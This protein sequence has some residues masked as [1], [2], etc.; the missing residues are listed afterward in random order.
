MHDR[1]QLTA[2]IVLILTLLFLGD[3]IACRAARGA[4][5]RYAL[6]VAIR[7]YPHT[8]QLSNLV[9]TNRDAERLA[10]SLI[11]ASFSAEDLT[12][13]YDDATDPDLR[14]TRRNILAQLERMIAKADQDD[15]ILVATTSHGLVIGQQ[16]FICTSETTDAAVLGDDRSRHELL[17][18]DEI[19]QRMSKAKSDYRLLVVDACRTT[20]T[21]N[22]VS[23]L[24]KPPHGV[25]VMTS[26]S[27]GQVSY[28]SDQIVPNESRAIFTDSLCEAFSG[29]AD[30]VSGNNNRSLFLFEV[31]SY[32]YAR[33]Q[34]ECAK[35]GLPIEQQQTPELFGG[36]VPPFNVGFVERLVDDPTLTS[37]DPN[38]ERIQ[39]GRL[40]AQVGI[41]HVQEAERDFLH[42]YRYRATRNDALYRKHAQRLSY[43]LGNYLD[44]ALA[45]DPNCTLA[46]IGIGN[47]RRTTGEYG[48]ALE[49]FRR[50]GESLELY[51]RTSPQDIRQLYK[52]HQGKIE[53]NEDLRASEG[54]SQSLPL[55]A[56]P[57]PASP[58]LQSMPAHAKLRISGSTQVADQTWL[59]VSAVNDRTLERRGWV[60]PDWV[61]WFA[62][63]ADFYTPASPMNGGSGFSRASATLGRLDVASS[64]L[65]SLADR[66]SEPGRRLGEVQ[67]AIN[68]IPGSG[69][70]PGLGYLGVARSYVDLP[71]S[72]ARRG[73]YYASLPSQYVN[74]AN[75]WAGLSHGFYT[76]H[77][78]TTASQQQRQ[79]A[80][81]AQT[82]NSVHAQRAVIQNDPWNSNRGA[83][84]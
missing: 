22:L 21:R 67:S 27:E 83:A 82:L 79:E 10:Q 12:I 6:I 29:K 32:V 56:S 74:A 81:E 8:T 19:T 73:A 54:I 30:L 34:R 20:H 36:V 51:A 24:R 35:L 60:H 39:S 11:Q 52:T 58:R 16:S 70:I 28:M 53:L 68:R 50:A 57:D 43:A 7:D 46:H 37:S 84:S 38:M 44:S 59:Q 55:L 75:R 66:L 61:I 15:V 3:W 31:Y 63:A 9:G 80:W 14:P 48:L 17:A 5:K 1:R 65:H 25:W 41:Q 78:R 45:S 40:L 26:C 18:I 4:T 71:A 23:Q 69:F 42:Y 62:E 64:N 49:S 77:Q 2:R 13:V 33:T 72:Y 76:G 47:V